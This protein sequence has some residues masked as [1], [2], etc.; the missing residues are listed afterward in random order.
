MT[1]GNIGN[2]L[3]QIC[4]IGLVAIGMTFVILSGSIDLSVGSIV[5]LSGVLFGLLAHGGVPCGAAL[6]AAITGGIFIGLING[7]MVAYGKIPS[8]IATLG[9]MGIARGIALW[10]TEGRS[11]TDIPDAWINFIGL[12]PLG[13]PLMGVLLIA[14]FLLC[15]LL[16]RKTIGG[17]RLVAMG[18]NAQGAWMCGIRIRGYRLFVFAMAGLFSALGGLVLSGRLSAAHPLSGEFYEIDAIAAVVI[19]GGAIT[20]GRASFLGTLIGVLILGVLRDG[21]SLLNVG[22][23]AQQV[24]VGVVVVAAVALD[25]S[26]RKGLNIQ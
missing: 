20:G 15:E 22:A 26:R 19:G 12:S 9:M 1:A 18:C 25:S 21:L 2:V 14:I 4:P 10:L 8:F 24:L 7:V 6:A 13:I 16:L 17:R 11:I 5:G 3:I 23:Y